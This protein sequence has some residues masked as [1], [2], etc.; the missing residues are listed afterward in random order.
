MAVE[1]MSGE[2]RALLENAAA[3]SC[4]ELL[5]RRYPETIHRVIVGNQ[6][7]RARP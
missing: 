7:A 1:E 3:Q 2:D 4:W 6:D 5:A